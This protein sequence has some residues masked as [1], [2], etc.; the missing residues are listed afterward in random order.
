MSMCELVVAN[1]WDKS[2]KQ[3]VGWDEND[4]KLGDGEGE[5]DGG[6]R[7]KGRHGSKVW[8]SHHFCPGLGR[9][10]SVRCSW[11][12]QGS[13]WQATRVAVIER[14]KSA[15]IPVSWRPII[16]RP[17]LMCHPQGALLP[18]LDS[19]PVPRIRLSDQSRVRIRRLVA[20]I[21]WCI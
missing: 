1:G 2:T 12:T 19:Q 15:T 6:N 16:G 21:R 17:A 14:C 10:R 20:R 8:H 11:G 9:G 13:R 18:Y 4:V 3:V 5:S 7:E